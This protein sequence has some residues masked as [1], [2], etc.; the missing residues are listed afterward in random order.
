MC[1][2]HDDNISELQKKV[3]MLQKYE[4]DR[5][6]CCQ[7]NMLKAVPVI[8]DCLRKQMK[9]RKVLSNVKPDGSFRVQ[10]C[11]IYPKINTDSVAPNLQYLQTKIKEN[12]AQDARLKQLYV[13][14]SV[15][16]GYAIEI[17]DQSRVCFV[18]CVPFAMVMF[19]AEKVIYYRRLRLRIVCTGKV[20][21]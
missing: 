14:V 2:A 17:L 15:Y 4:Y 12:L 21:E 3:E 6:L 10:L 20:S 11:T 1:A 5:Y 16:D 19:A 8:S 13:A 18:C 9:S 7:A